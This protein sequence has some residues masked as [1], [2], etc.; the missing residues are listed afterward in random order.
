MRF[1]EFL[2]SQVGE[3]IQGKL[4]G[5]QEF[6]NAPM[7]GEEPSLVLVVHRTT[8]HLVASTE[9]IVRGDK[10]YILVERL[11]ALLILRIGSVLLA[12]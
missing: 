2:E 6:S 8:I 11:E 9:L 5:H 10:F 12:I 1:L 4:R 7:L 3:L